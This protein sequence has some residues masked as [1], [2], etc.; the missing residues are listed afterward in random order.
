LEKKNIRNNSVKI[1]IHDEIKRGLNSNNAYCH[2]VQN[3]S[4]FR[5]LSKTVK[6][7]IHKTIILP[8]VLYESESRSLTLRGKKISLRVFE[9]RVLRIFE[10][11]RNEVTGALR[12]ELHNLYSSPSTIG[13]I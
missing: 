9:N 6:I 5:L 7:I 4:S 2:P 10:P 11:K 3:L 8:A 12:K 13:I 1:F